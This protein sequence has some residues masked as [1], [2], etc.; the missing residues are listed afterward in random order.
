MIYYVTKKTNKLTILPTEKK[1]NTK[2]IWMQTLHFGVQLQAQV[3]NHCHYPVWF[4][5]IP[6]FY[7][8]LLK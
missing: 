5:F 2:K 7:F 8:N 6:S 1:K 4:L 3:S